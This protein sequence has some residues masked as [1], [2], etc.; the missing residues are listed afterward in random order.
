MKKKILIA[1][2]FMMIGGSTTSLISILQ[3]IDYSRYDIDLLL[4]KRGF[5][6][7]KLVPPGVKVL[8]AALPFKS[9]REELMTKALKPNALLGIIK[10]RILPYFMKK[11]Y[12]GAVKSQLVAKVNANLSRKIAQEYDCAIAFIEGWPTEYVANYVEASKK[13]AWYHLDY[14][15]AGFNPKYDIKPYYKYN[16]IVLVSDKCKENFDKVFTQYAYKSLCIENIL[17][18]EY[19]ERMASAYKQEQIEAEGDVL[20]LVTVCRLSF[21]HKGI[22]RGV[23]ALARLMNEN[24]LKRGFK[25]YIIGDGED[26]IELEKMITEVG[27]SDCIYLL[28]AMNNPLP[29]VKSADIFFLPSRFEGKPMAV[30]E[31]QMCGIPVLVTNYASAKMQVQTGIDGLIVANDDGGVA[32]GLKTVINNPELVLQFKKNVMNMDYS[33]VVEI[34]KIEGLINE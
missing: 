10:S 14:I 22:D 34:K 20:N 3:N 18:K 16:S 1:Y 13:I 33:N 4:M 21:N 25:W 23:L 26:K 19:I 6:L 24:Q 17:S 7:D 15:A 31:A 8:E 27:L 2:T 12:R 5:P 32:E 30:T 11:Y 9:K 28:G 29:Y